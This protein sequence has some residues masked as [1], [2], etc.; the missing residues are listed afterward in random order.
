VSNLPIEDG[1]PEL[2]SL[3]PRPPMDDEMDITPMIDMTFLLL[4]FFH[5]DF[6]DDGRE[7]VRHSACEERHNGR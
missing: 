1:E 6:E 7:N 3:P 4:I 5:S 2:V